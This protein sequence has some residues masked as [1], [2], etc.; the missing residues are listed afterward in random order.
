MKQLTEQEIKFIKETGWTPTV[1]QCAEWYKTIWTDEKLELGQ[2]YRELR[3]AYENKY[4]AIA[5]EV[6]QNQYG[7][8]LNDLYKKCTEESDGITLEEMAPYLFYI[9]FTKDELE[10]LTDETATKWLKD[11]QYYCGYRKW[12]GG[13]LKYVYEALDVYSGDRV[14][15]LQDD[16]EV[17]NISKSECPNSWIWSK[18]EIILK[19]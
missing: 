2:N 14:F 11:F 10:K 1:Y 9:F 8:D 12:D 18:P 15:Y 17:W 13:N 5:E 3:E 6:A 7:F 16:G 4:R 19:I